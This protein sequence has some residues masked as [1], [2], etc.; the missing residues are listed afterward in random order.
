MTRKVDVFLNRLSHI[1]QVFLVA[2]AVF[3]YFYTVRPIYQKEILSEDIAKKEV[4]LK[5]IQKQLDELY[6]QLR[7]EL[8]RKI[9]TGA[10]YNCSP[11][12]TLMMQPPRGDALRS[13]DFDVE[14][15]E[16]SALL[17]KDV[18]SCI[19]ES[20]LNNP[21]LKDLRKI[22]QDK[23]I[24]VIRSLNPKLIEL[25]N[26]YD[27]IFRDRDYLF[28]IGEEESFFVKEMENFRLAN[29]IKTEKNDIRLKEIYTLSGAT[30]VVS[31]YGMKFNRLIMELV[32]IDK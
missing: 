16:L 20:T 29:G 8:I 21:L 6:Y 19:I 7:S 28:K 18:Y 13:K 32:K 4:E 2:L 23:L 1:S 26:E 31:D 15:S 14:M 5:I 9:K 11:V 25:R 12:T 10:T 22:D 3:G 30:S 24:D 27:L 17:S